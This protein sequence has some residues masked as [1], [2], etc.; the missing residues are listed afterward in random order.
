MGPPLAFAGLC[1]L[2]LL[3]VH[4]TMGHTRGESNIKQYISPNTSP[5]SVKESR[6]GDELEVLRS[7]QQDLV[8]KLLFSSLPSFLLPLV[9]GQSLTLPTCSFT[10]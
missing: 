5:V 2:G 7:S 4:R 1:Q 9:A 10:A 6:A 8:Q 3:V